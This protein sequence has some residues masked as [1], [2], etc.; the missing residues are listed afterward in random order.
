MVLPGWKPHG[1]MAGYWHGKMGEGNGHGNEDDWEEK[2]EEK[3][4]KQEKQEKK[5][6]KSKKR[7]KRKKK[8]KER[9]STEY[10]L[11]KKSLGIAVVPILT[12]LQ[13]QDRWCR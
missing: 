4:E 6:K 1:E 2:P 3:Q 9:N 7:K 13:K 12:V 11:L 5:S 10:H 8:K